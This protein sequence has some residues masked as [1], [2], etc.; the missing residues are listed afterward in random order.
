MHTCQELK[1]NSHTLLTFVKPKKLNIN[2]I[3]SGCDLN[4]ASSFLTLST[5]G[6][7]SQGV[8]MEFPMTVS[9]KWDATVKLSKARPKIRNTKKRL[10][11]QSAMNF[12]ND[13]MGE[14]S[15]GRGEDTLN[16]V[17][18]IAPN[19]SACPDMSLKHAC[20]FEKAVTH[21]SRDC[22]VSLRLLPL[23]SCL[24]FAYVFFLSTSLMDVLGHVCSPLF[25]HDHL[26]YSLFVGQHLHTHFVCARC[27]C[28]HYCPQDRFSYWPN[29]ANEANGWP[30]QIGCHHRLL[31]SSSR[32]SCSCDSGT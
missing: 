25:Q 30:Q 2:G 10:E 15:A 6:C 14:G 12:F 29:D 1:E 24:A 17:E 3:D 11:G 28:A 19:E 13:M 20:P 18:T 16:L 32:H 8:Y 9:L 5:E 22:M 27:F 31:W 21:L 23:G 4:L 7:A 26:R